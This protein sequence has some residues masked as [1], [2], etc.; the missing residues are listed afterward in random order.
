MGIVSKIVRQKSWGFEAAPQ[1]N[2][3]LCLG[4]WDK[5][6]PNAGPY[7]VENTLLVARPRRWHSLAAYTHP[8]RLHTPTLQHGTVGM[9]EH[10]WSLCSVKRP[11]QTPSQG[12]GA[13]RAGNQWEGRHSPGLGRFPRCG[14]GRVRVCACMCVC[15]ERWGCEIAALRV[16]SHI[17][18]LGKSGGHKWK[19]PA[20]AK[21]T[22]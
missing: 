16:K 12:L 19:T 1:N 3:L 10:E 11:N 2:P 7:H 20:T 18:N 15:G 17:S 13:G 22:P 9:A 5:C 21:Q 8:H 14:L 6:F 4:S